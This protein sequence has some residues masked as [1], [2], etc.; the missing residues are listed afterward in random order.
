MADYSEQW[1]DYRRVRN[2]ALL[3]L[4]GIIPVGFLRW[5]L[6]RLF[7]TAGV[8]ASV[9]AAVILAWFFAALFTGA[10]VTVW[11]CPRCGKN[12]GFKWWYKSSA[13]IARRCAHCGLAKFA[14][15]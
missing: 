7:G 4:F 14:N 8:T 11:R 3:A 13:L 6:E 1:R 9:S 10:R 12:F 2:E 15:N 5:L